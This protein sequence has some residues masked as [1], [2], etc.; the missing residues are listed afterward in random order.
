MSIKDLYW[1]LATWHM[2]LPYWFM[3]IIIV[4]FIVLLYKLFKLTNEKNDYNRLYE[5]ADNC[6]KD[7][8]KELLNIT[9]KCK[10]KEKDIT[11]LNKDN[12]TVRKKLK[13]KEEIIIDLKKK[14]SVLQEKNKSLFNTYESEKSSFV[15][16]LQVKEKK[17]DKLGK[18]I[19]LNNE[20]YHKIEKEKK[21][22]ECQLKETQKILKQKIEQYGVLEKKC[23]RIESQNKKIES[24]K[25]LLKQEI[26]EQ[27]STIKQQTNAYKTEIRNLN[28]KVGRRDEKIEKI[29]KVLAETQKELQTVRNEKCREEKML[30]EIQETLKE[31]VQNKHMDKNENLIERI[32]RW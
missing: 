15:S 14:I 2:R 11:T 9:I 27:K 24:S 30:Q 7:S 31:K 6:L 17:I 8:K 5:I 18:D 28:I 21:Q 32:A 12:L 10:N 1:I 25:T 20:K 4:V 29:S 26:D 19:T 16:N 3:V 23:S 13:E 22:L